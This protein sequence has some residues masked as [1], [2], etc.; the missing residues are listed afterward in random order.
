MKTKPIVVVGSVNLDLVCSVERIPT[1]GETLSGEGFQT[2]HGGKGANQAVAVARLGHPVAMVAKVGDD[3]F[4]T[5]LRSGLREAGVSVRAVSVAKDISSGVAMISVDRQG[6]NS[7]VVVPGANGEMRPSD[8]EKA[9]PLLRSAGMILTQLEIPMET[10]ECLGLLARR[11]NVPLM[12]DPAPAGKLPLCLLKSI[13]FLTPNESETLALC[14]NSGG[15]NLNS[16]SAQQYGELLRNRGPESVIIKMGSQGAC[17]LGPNGF[18]RFV[19]AFKVKGVDTTAAGDAFNGAL[20][21]GVLE[22]RDLEDAV[23]FASAAAALSVTRMGAQPSLPN[24]LEV[25]RFIE[26]A[27]TIWASST[28]EVL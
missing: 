15:D 20:A 16:S 3:E 6:E 19:P 11:F 8:L 14:D 25:E 2:F 26:Q 28:S 9:T 12:L 10:V 24:R 22:G 27:R 5:R 4:G 1:R 23:V 18:T 17:V 21:V 13:A 7:I